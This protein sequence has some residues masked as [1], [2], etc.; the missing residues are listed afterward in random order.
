MKRFIAH[1][2]GLSVSFFAV[3]MA[4]L[5]LLAIVVALLSFLFW[6]IPPIPT[7]DILFFALRILLAVSMLITIVYAFSNDYKEA[8]QE[9]LS[10]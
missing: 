6:T 10:R 1:M 2:F 7:P 8:V 5:L 3:F 4:L 9:V